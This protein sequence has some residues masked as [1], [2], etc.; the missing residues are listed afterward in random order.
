MDWTAL[1]SSTQILSQVDTKYILSLFAQKF[2]FALVREIMYN[3]N[4]DAVGMFLQLQIWRINQLHISPLHCAVL[5]HKVQY[6]RTYRLRLHNYITY[7][8]LVDQD[9]TYYGQYKTENMEKTDNLLE[10]QNKQIKLGDVC[11][12]DFKESRLI[13]SKCIWAKCI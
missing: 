13:M 5:E 8:R 4:C 11:L 10:F 6:S 12:A 3:N 2:P 7:G 1:N 9:T